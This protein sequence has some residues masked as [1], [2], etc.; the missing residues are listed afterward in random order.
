MVIKLLCDKS[1]VLEIVLVSKY[2]PDNTIWIRSPRLTNSYWLCF[3]MVIFYVYV[4]DHCALMGPGCIDITVY[5]GVEVSWN[6]MAYAQKPDF[7]FRRNER[8]H[9]NR[10]WRQ[11]SRLLAAEVCASAVVR[12]DTPCS[13]VVRRVLATHSIRQFPLR[14]PSRASSCAITFQL[15]ST[16][17]ELQRNSRPYRG[18]AAAQ[19]ITALL[20]PSKNVRKIPNKYV[21]H[22]I[23]AYFTVPAG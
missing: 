5:C 19:S 6:V 20:L 7:V 8:V 17:T 1:A 11:F 18:R 15:E 23:T 9:L 4:D 13:E 14:F 22:R 16:T 10:R 21:M 2:T 3:R 12:P